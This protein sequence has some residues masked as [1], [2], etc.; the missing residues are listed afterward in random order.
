MSAGNKVAKDAGE[1]TPL[2]DKDVKDASFM[3]SKVEARLLDLARSSI[4]DRRRKAVAVKRKRNRAVDAHQR[5]EPARQLQCHRREG[6]RRATRRRRRRRAEKGP[7]PQSDWQ[8]PRARS[9]R[10]M[11]QKSGR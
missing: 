3:S 7:R 6:H 10:D 1:G 2:T 5:R 11:R 4:G 8:W 9:N